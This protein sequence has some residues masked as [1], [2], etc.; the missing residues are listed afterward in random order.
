M[1]CSSERFDSCV[2]TIFQNA[3]THKFSLHCLVIVILTT[4]TS[5]KMKW[6]M[7]LLKHKVIFVVSCS[8][9]ILIFV[10]L[11]DLGINGIIK[12]DNGMVGNF[13][14]HAKSLFD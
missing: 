9:N 12:T 3:V 2:I 6:Q 1:F 5:D 14:T 13:L 11:S 10:M 8:L 7:Q 4:R